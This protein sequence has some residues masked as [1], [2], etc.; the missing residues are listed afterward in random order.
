MNK[1]GW[2]IHALLSACLATERLSFGRLGSA[3]MNLL[4]A[5]YFDV[6]FLGITSSLA[7]LTSAY[8]SF[9][10]GIPF[11]T[12]RRKVKQKCGCRLSSL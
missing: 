6:C 2:K 10:F 1:L 8:F 3:I 11:S 7:I 4:L 12:G 5:I 9:T